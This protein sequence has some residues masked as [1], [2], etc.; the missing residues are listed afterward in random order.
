MKKI[1]NMFIK[2]DN[3]RILKMTPKTTRVAWQSTYETEN[4]KTYNSN[5]R[6]CALKWILR[7]HS[8]NRDAR[9][10]LKTELFFYYPS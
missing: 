4:I 3:K 10:K 1:L 8:S 9:V 5:E 7:G 2:N 6:H